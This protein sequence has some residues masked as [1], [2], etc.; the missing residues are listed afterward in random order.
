[1]LVRLAAAAPDVRLV[2]LVCA[3]RRYAAASV[4]IVVASDPH[5]F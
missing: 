1:M 2:R 3:G 5:A 4:R